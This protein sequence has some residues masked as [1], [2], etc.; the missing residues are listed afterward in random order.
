MNLMPIDASP[1][2]HTE[3]IV[4]NR[5][6]YVIKLDFQT[7]KGNPGDTPCSNCTTHPIAAP[8]ASSGY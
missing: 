1:H 5:H 2:E 8:A 6:G 7:I 4:G 3:Q